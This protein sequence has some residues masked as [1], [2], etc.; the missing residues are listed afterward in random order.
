M[1]EFDL[2][3]TSTEAVSSLSRDTAAAA[4]AN[5]EF[6]GES[7]AG[8]GESKGEEGGATTESKGEEETKA[9][10]SD[11]PTS[12]HDLS[13][14]SQAFSLNWVFGYEAQDVRNSLRYVNGTD[15]AFSAAAVGVVMT[16]KP[17]VQRFNRTTDCNAGCTAG[18][19]GLAASK[20]GRYVAV[21]ERGV[22]PKVV[23]F[24][25]SSG[26]T[27]SVLYGHKVGVAHLA[28]SH[29]GSKL[30][31]VGIDPAHTVIMYVWRLGAAVLGVV[32]VVVVCVFVFVFVWMWH[33]RI[34]GHRWLT[35]L[36]LPSPTLLAG[37]TGAAVCR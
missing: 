18:I 5:A 27:L 34:L 33:H 1:R 13:R 11:A 32:V 2:F 8:G 23:V 14:P 24:D 30:L 12:G 3:E 28:F 22:R 4:A 31:T 26:K 29:G 15:V 36:P 7:K 16:P 25:A 19:I 6:Q 35:S 20:C 17:R 9:E 21:G 10:P 37:T